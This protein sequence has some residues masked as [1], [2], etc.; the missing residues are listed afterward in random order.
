[1][2]RYIK[3]D[4]NNIMRWI[5]FYAICLIFFLTMV[6]LIFTELGFILIVIVIAIFLLIMI[7]VLTFKI[8]RLDKELEELDGL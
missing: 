2:E 8:R 5:G 3:I 6:F 7:I 4:K 1:M